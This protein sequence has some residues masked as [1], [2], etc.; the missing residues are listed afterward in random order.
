MAKKVDENIEKLSERYSESEMLLLKRFLDD[1][2][3]LFQG[4][5]K[6]LHKLL[7]DM[8]KIH[9]SI[10]F[11]MNHTT[12]EIEPP[13]SSCDCPKQSSIPFLDTSC[14]LIEGKIVLDLY[15]KPTDRNQYLLT[16][17]CHPIETTKNV[18]FSL[19][20]RIN[21]ICTY[22]ETRD[23]RLI[24]LKNMLLDREYKEGMINNAINRAKA[25]P[26]EQ[27][28]RQ[29]VHTTP[30]KRPIFVVTYDPRL[31]NI[32]QIQLKH[33]RSMKS[34]D[35]YLAEVFPIHPLTAY[36]RQK[37]IK[38][39]VIKA[40][41]HTKQRE[42]RNIKGMSKCNKPCTACPFI[43]EDKTIKHKGKEWFINKKVDCKTENCVYMIKCTKETCKMIYIGETERTICE[44]F[45][46]HRGYIKQKILSQ[47]TGSHF[48]MP[49]HT[50]SDMKVTVVEKVKKTDKIYRKERERYF[51]RYFNAFYDGM[52]RAP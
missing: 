37:N 33:W 4:T 24:E 13:S 41:L 39:L 17:S 34:Q 6:N 23:K 7:E 30:V 51:I 15:K 8:N 35:P 25:I 9:P 38:D 43:S 18:P 21:R 19:A 49:G 2:F 14:T 16:S 48:N 22:S 5:T 3:S 40:K 36:K 11:T 12:P 10:K 31:P 28:I 47:P 27:A 44:R 52:N 32:Q 42:K 46:D 45:S 26:R 29:V 20:M 1:I 50:L